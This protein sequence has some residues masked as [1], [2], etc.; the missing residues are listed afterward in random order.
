[1][2][3]AARSRCRTAWRLAW[4]TTVFAVLY[5]WSTH[6]TDGRGDV[7][8]GVFGWERAIPFID[9]TVL[10][11]LSICV[12]FVASFFLCRDKAALDRHSLRL[13]LALGISLLCYALLPLRFN[14]ERPATTGALGLLFDG[15]SAFDMPYNRAPSLHISVL[16]LLWVRYAPFVRGALRLA[17]QGWFVLIG[18]SV[19]TTY[20]H[21]VIDVPAGLAVGLLCV[22]LVRERRRPAQRVVHRRVQPIAWAAS[23]SL[24]TASV[25]SAF[26]AA[27][28]GFVFTE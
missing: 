28:S 21:H 26:R 6:D 2:Q 10:P 1:M 16:V 27:N 5:R 20:Q 3:T 9:W 24:R 15:L 14:F 22:A 17:L 11:Y 12:F 4:L 19:L 18:V 8:R 23:T 25:S 13:L 7:G